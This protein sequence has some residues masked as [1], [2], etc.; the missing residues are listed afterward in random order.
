[1]G[2]YSAVMLL[3]TFLKLSYNNTNN[4]PRPA[5]RPPKDHRS[6]TRGRLSDN[7]RIAKDH[8]GPTRVQ[9]MDNPRTTQPL[10]SQ[11]VRVTADPFGW[12]TAMQ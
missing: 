1:M 9:P 8:P 10:V 11:W 12:A 7:P 4:N 6:P 3:K 5:Q 2:A